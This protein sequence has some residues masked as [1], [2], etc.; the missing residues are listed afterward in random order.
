[1]HKV[2]WRNEHWA[3]KN[4]SFKN[5]SM[6]NIM[7]IGAFLFLGTALFS[8]TSEKGKSTSVDSTNLKG[9]APATYEKGTDPTDTT[10]LLPKEDD[11]GKRA[12]T[13]MESEQK[14]R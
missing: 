6:K 4:C 11:T 2:S 7:L 10:D 12:N 3:F 13:M 8:C 5:S 9:Y 1:M 14:H